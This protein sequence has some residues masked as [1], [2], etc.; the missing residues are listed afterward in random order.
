MEELI[1]SEGGASNIPPHPADQFAAKCID[2]I[3]YGLVEMTW[4]GRTKKKHRGCLRFFCGEYAEGDDG[5]EFPLWVDAWFTLTLNEKG[6]LRPF[7]ESWRGR[8]FT[9]DELKQFNLAQLV[10]A[11]AFI[12]VVH[13]PKNGK[14]YANIASIMRLPRGTEPV[15]PPADYVRVKDRPK[16]GESNGSAPSP[17]DQDDDDL[18]F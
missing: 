7:L 6:S 12:Q 13:K 18:P 9:A 5:K 15:Q 16:D 2:I 1:I 10:G 17:F 11:D 14:T 8:P 4:Q 3:D